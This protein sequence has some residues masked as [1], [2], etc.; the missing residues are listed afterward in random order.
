[1]KLKEGFKEVS[2]RV[3][4]E[5]ILIYKPSLTFKKMKEKMS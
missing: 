5:N 3:K 1:M 2:C 4:A